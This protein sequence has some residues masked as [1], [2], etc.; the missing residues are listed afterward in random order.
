[1]I[2]VLGYQADCGA[3]LTG[4]GFVFRKAYQAAGFCIQI[5][6]RCILENFIFRLSP[7]FCILLIL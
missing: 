3:D 1:M 5:G 6:M 7:L 2:E 4:L